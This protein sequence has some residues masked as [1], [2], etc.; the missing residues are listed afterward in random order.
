VKV[1]DARRGGRKWLRIPLIVLVALA[2]AYPLA[3]NLFLKFGDAPPK[4]E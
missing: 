1:R 3:A 4:C 2:C